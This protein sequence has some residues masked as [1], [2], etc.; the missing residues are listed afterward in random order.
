LVLRCIKSIL[1]CSPQPR[2]IIVIDDGS[3]PPYNL[4][5]IAGLCTVIRN[6]GGEGLTCSLNKA[7]RK[8]KTR[9]VMIMDDD[10][11]L[12]H[13]D[14]LKRAIANFQAS[15]NVALVTPKMINLYRNRQRKVIVTH[16]RTTISLL[17]EGPVPQSRA[18]IDF[19][20]SNGI[21]IKASVLRQVRGF[22]E[23]LIGHACRFETDLAIKIRK[24]SYKIVCDPELVVFHYV[25]AGLSAERVREDM[26]NHLVFLCN[27][28]S[29]PLFKSCLFLA[30]FSFYV[31]VHRLSPLHA[32]HGFLDGLKRVYRIV[33]DGTARH[34]NLA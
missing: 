18:F 11:C 10:C 24:S 16:L 29:H 1:K 13:S 25:E 7:L 14:Y 6:E 34:L 23:N 20:V 33:G 19:P 3:I 32:V 15:K 8:V 26:R 28:Y 21:I 2:E 9:Y 22:D 27:H 5:M 4:S 17:C 31:L 12:A 30:T